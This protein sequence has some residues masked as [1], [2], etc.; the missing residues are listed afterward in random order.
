MSGAALWGG[1]AGVQEAWGMPPSPGPEWGSVDRMIRDDQDS[2][3]RLLQ[4]GLVVLV[5][6][7]RAEVMGQRG[8]AY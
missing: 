1:K 6:V 4:L 5:S 3:S 2:L 7:G 8:R